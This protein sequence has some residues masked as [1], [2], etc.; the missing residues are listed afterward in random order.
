MTGR[1]DAQLLDLARII[2]G[3]KENDF[4]YSHDLAVQEAILQASGMPLDRT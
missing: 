4:S 1:Y 3:E 2:R